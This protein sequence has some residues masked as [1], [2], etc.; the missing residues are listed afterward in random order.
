MS[1]VG[2]QKQDLM[3]DISVARYSLYIQILGKVCRP[4]DWG[5]RI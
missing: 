3:N 2:L 4:R 5:S 1:T